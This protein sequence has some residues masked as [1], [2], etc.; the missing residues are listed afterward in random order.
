MRLTLVLLTLA[1]TVAAAEPRVVLKLTTPGYEVAMAT[2]V[3]EAW[4]VRLAKQ[5]NTEKGRVYTCVTP[6]E[7][8][9][10]QQQ[11]APGPDF[12]P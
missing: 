11:E 7:G 1:A 6:A 10:L 2:A 8:K 12:C 5:L 9:R 3:S 4:C